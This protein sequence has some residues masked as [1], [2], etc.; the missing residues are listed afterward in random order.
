MK[1]IETDYLNLW[2]VFFS[3]FFFAIQK[4]SNFDLK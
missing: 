4:S 1:M 2:K 3:V